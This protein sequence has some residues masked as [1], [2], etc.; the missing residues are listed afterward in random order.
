MSALPLELEAEI[1]EL[2]AHVYPQDIITFMLVAQRVHYWSVLVRYGHS[3]L[4][5]N[6]R[7]RL[8]PIL[9]ANVI[10]G[11]NFAP[12]SGDHAN[13]GVLKRPKRPRGVKRV[14][15]TYHAPV[16][17]S[18][19]FLKACTG[20]SALACW[21]PDTAAIELIPA[22]RC[23]HN[24]SISTDNFALLPPMENLTHLE[25]IVLEPLE[26]LDI[27]M[28]PNLKNIGFLDF[29]GKATYDFVPH[30]LEADLELIYILFYYWDVE[31]VSAPWQEDER[32]VLMSRLEVKY[33]ALMSWKEDAL[34]PFAKRKRDDR[35]A[36][37]QAAA[38][39]QLETA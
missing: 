27:T 13:T 34:W 3:Q 7:Y 24:L 1:F 29:P 10:I 5:D 35:R 15:I 11:G 8:E 14:C 36:K 9:Y 4:A 2:A 38:A 19:A 18:V 25:L 23:L 21:C 16:E 28:H 22:F 32:V 30:L 26:R 12:S 20:L 39:A 6:V 31:S 33:N 37:L 17:P